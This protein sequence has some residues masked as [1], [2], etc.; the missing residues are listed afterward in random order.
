MVVGGRERA[1]AE[2]SRDVE[3]APR[4]S[5]EGVLPCLQ[6]AAPFV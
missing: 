4:V 1:V 5:D 3:L 6:A 2:I